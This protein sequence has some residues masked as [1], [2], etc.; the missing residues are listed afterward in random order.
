MAEPRVHPATATLTRRTPPHPAALKFV[1]GNK[2]IVGMTSSEGESFAFRSAVAVDGPVEV[3]GSPCRLC[4]WRCSKHA[5]LGQAGRRAP[6]VC[7]R[8]QKVASPLGAAQAWMTGV[9]AEMRA[10]LQAV[11]KE[12]VWNYAH[13]PRPAWIGASLGMVTLAG[14]QVRLGRGRGRGL[15]ERRGCLLGHS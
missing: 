15:V 2:T 6:L 1:R 14:S 4:A 5:C 10:T 8:L 3:R 9:E 12:G 7:A 11:T 13:T